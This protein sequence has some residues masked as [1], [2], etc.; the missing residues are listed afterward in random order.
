MMDREEQGSDE[1]QSRRKPVPSYVPPLAYD[2]ALL[3]STA[4]TEIHDWNHKPDS[5]H[6]SD[7]P[8]I[9]EVRRD[10]QSKSTSV[11]DGTEYE[12]VNTLSDG[13]TKS[14]GTRGPRR[15]RLYFLRAWL[16]EIFWCVT[17]IACIVVLVTVLQYYDNK[18]LPNWPLGL[19]L[20]TVVAFISTF[21]RTSFV[22]PVV[23]SLSQYKW[24]WYKSPRPL[25]DF[26]I[27]DEASR[28]PWGSLKLLFAT[29]G[30]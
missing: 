7:E 23:Q 9:A 28:G 2:E 13:K 12:L 25:K 5:K 22:V 24:N 4:H 10:L 27:F 6:T 17:G 26:K 19:T 18:P 11:S 29:R 1:R 20:N 21:C 14:R 30:R 8:Q 15:R 3:L 16:P